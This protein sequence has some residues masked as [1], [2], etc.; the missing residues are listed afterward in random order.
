[1]DVGLIVDSSS[2]V[3]RKNF[4]D[5]KKFL[6]EFVTILKNLNVQTHIG[7]IRYNHKPQLIFNFKEQQS[8]HHIQEKLGNMTYSPGIDNIDKQ[9][10]Q[11]QQQQE[12][13]SVVQ[14]SACWICM[15][16][17]P[18]SNLTLTTVWICLG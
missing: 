13:G 17:D 10:Q 9:Q 7:L 1:M 4:E 6:V 15:R 5:V 2:S 16:D 8:L 11:Q 14:W 3:Q 12:G 18:G